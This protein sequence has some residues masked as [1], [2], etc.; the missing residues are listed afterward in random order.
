MLEQEKRNASVLKQD[1]SQVISYTQKFMDLQD[2]ISNTTSLYIEYWQEYLKSKPGKHSP[3]LPNNIVLEFLVEKGYEI[4]FKSQEIDDILK[5]LEEQ[6]PDTT[7]AMILM[8]LFQKHV[9]EDDY[10]AHDI[11]NK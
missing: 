2:L 8:A 5:A 11:S 1:F 10:A 7:K 4:S 3:Y 6:N 9:A